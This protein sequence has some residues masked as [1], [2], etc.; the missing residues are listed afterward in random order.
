MFGV[1]CSLYS[2][3]NWKCPGGFTRCVGSYQCTYTNSTCNGVN[4]CRRGSDEHQSLC[5]TFTPN[6]LR[7][8]ERQTG[9]KHSLGVARHHRNHC[10]GELPFPPLFF[11]FLPFPLSFLTPPFPQ[12]YTHPLSSPHALFPPLNPARESAEAL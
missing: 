7:F 5:G 3:G 11:P 6:T 1:D 2:A 12:L 10:L 8:L 4:N 9:T